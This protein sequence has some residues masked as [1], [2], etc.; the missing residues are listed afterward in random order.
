MH[1]FLLHKLRTEFSKL[2]VSFW[3]DDEGAVLS[4]EYV[5]LSG[6]L[7]TGVVPGLVAARNSINAAYANMG[8]SVLASIPSPSYSG[9]SV[10]GPNGHA[11]ASVQGVNLA[12][13]TQVS[14]LQ[15]TQLAPNAIP[16]P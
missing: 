14:Y 2:F 10:G 11:I 1:T 6:V 12:S 7:V 8:N 5:L 13:P 15:A 16:A 9:F 3:T 4:V